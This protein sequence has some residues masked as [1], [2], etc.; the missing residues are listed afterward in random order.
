MTDDAAPATGDGAVVLAR[1]DA[2]PS[3]AE[4]VYDTLKRFIIEQRLNPGSKLSVP[5]LAEQL[6]VSRT[7]VKEAVDRLA[8]EG[9]V[10][11][12]PKRGAFVAILRQRD[13]EEIYEMREVLEGLASR[14]AAKRADPEFLRSLR[15]IHQRGEAAVQH[16]DLAAHTHI[17]LEFHRLIRERAENRRLIRALETLQQQ[18]R[19]VFKTSATI[20]GRM[21]KAI[22]EHR[23]IL[24]ALE[25]GDPEEAERA[26]RNHVRWIR[27]AVVRFMAE[28]GGLRP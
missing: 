20:P 13:V 16:S 5:R 8:Q 1:V 26:T 25:R 9:L 21:Q 17:D 3:L 2:G 27:E 18:I 12:L 22:A 24:Q 10:T 19:I 7:P 23:E 14:L 6:G 11:I 28:R 15:L 4:R